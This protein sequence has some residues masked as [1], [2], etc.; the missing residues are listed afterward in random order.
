MSPAYQAVQISH[1]V[2]DFIFQFPQYAEV[3]HETSNSI[4]TLSVKTERDLCV[5]SRTLLGSNIQHTTFREP[6]I[7]YA[8]TAIALVPD[9]GIKRFCRDFDMAM[10]PAY[11]CRGGLD[12][13]KIERWDRH[14]RKLK[15]V[16][17][18]MEACEQTK[19][20][21]VLEHG[22]AVNFCLQLLLKST[23]L[24]YISDDP[25]FRIPQWLFDH[26]GLLYSRL[27]DA[28]TIEKYT[29]FHD[30]GKPYCSRI[31]KKG[32]KH[33]VNH[34]EVSYKTWMKKCGGDE[35][36]GRLI[37]MD[38][39]IHLLKADEVEEFASRPEAATL[40]LVGLAEIHAN[41]K[42]FGGIDSTSFKIKWKQIDRRGKA[43]CK[44]LKEQEDAK[45][46]NK[47]N[48]QNDF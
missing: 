46:G 18:D 33:F 9:K 12:G 42:M 43:I 28:Y 5:L 15:Q 14:E 30:C 29:I 13:A 1:A 22:R 2:A 37:K 17:R 41:A 24:Q 47:E 6:D 26:W 21:S 48:R 44:L 23:H 16:V 40:L 19:G 35:Q 8:I 25:S 20:Q 32:R 45:K 7:G 3:W 34:A 39:D 36:V 10:R 38:M 27:L 31:D 4:I 11:R